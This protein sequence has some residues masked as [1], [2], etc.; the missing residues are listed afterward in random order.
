MHITWV[1]LYVCVVE[2][3]IRGKSFLLCSD[4]S[5]ELLNLLQILTF[6]KAG[7]QYVTLY[8]FWILHEQTNVFLFHDLNKIVLDYYYRNNRVE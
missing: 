6:D 5:S 4:N 1:N 8:G 3:N 2:K 7:Q